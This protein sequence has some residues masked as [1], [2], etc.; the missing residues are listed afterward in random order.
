[1]VDPRPIWVLTYYQ[2]GEGPSEVVSVHG[3]GKDALEAAEEFMGTVG[4]RSSWTGSSGY[5]IHDPSAGV[6]SLDEAVLR[7]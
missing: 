6:L 7:G 4:G 3:S 2:P 5:W 1:V